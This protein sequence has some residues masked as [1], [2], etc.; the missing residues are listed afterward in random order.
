[1]IAKSALVEYS[2]YKSSHPCGESFC[3]KKRK[4]Y[5]SSTF[6]RSDDVL[7]TRHGLRRGE[8]RVIQ[9][10]SCLLVHLRQ[11]MGV[12]IKGDADVCMAQAVLYDLSV[13]AS[14]DHGSSIAVPKIV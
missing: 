4:C 11:N 8:Q 14:S 2:R 1:M 10:L 3:C 7:L 5:R 6:Y 12:C 13:D 9:L